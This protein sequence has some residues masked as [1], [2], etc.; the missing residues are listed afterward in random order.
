[1][2]EDTLYLVSDVAKIIHTN[3]NYVYKLINTGLLPA[4]KL[5][6]LKVRKMALDEFCRK[7]EGWDLTDPESP[8]PL[9]TDNFEKGGEIA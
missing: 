9:L 6:K 4:L 5:G 1:M 3:T 2:P 8:K 7:Y